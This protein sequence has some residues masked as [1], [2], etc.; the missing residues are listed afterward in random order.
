MKYK[1]ELPNDPRTPIEK[2]NG[3]VVI[4]MPAFVLGGAL[5]TL[6]KAIKQMGDDS[7]NLTNELMSMIYLQEHLAKHIDFITDYH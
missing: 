4:I 5:E 6:P 1:Q 3:D 2:E 7:Q